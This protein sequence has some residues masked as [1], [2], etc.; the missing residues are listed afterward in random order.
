MPRLR[1]E[2]VITTA[3]CLLVLGIA[4]CA[5]HRAGTAVVGESPQR[6]WSP[7]LAYPESLMLAGVEGSV[8]L[9]ARVDTNGRID[10][11]SIRV[12]RSTHRGFEAP[13]VNMLA[14]TRFRPAYLE[15]APTDAVVEVPVRFELGKPVEDSARAAEAMAEAERLARAGS[16]GPAMAAFAEA[17]RL[18][19][20]LSSSP[21]MWWTMCWYGS[22]WDYAEDVIATCDRAVALD[23]QSVR[24]RDA[25]GIAR[26]LTGD[27]PGA[28]ADFEVVIA[29][30]DSE[31]QRSE[32]GEWVRALRAQRNPVTP[33]V[34]ARLKHP[35]S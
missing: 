20:R 28:I 33:D 32:R 11:S 31:L 34:L 4:A 27:Y 6:L 24:A 7:P 5:T 18:D 26:A 2:R 17:G 30:S 3:A 12:L 1:L 21:T 35:G 13:A 14:G 19:T 15:G 22:V 8:M 16:I 23:P 29:A 25:R 10:R 9:R